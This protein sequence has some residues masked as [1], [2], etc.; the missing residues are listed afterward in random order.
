[1]KKNLMNYKLV[2]HNLRFTLRI[3]CTTISIKTQYKDFIL[4]IPREKSLCQNTK[5]LAQYL[6]STL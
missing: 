5:F 1:M 6:I 2:E 3:T 4:L